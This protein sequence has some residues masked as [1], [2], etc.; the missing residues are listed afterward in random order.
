MLAARPGCRELITAMD[1]ASKR[2]MEPIQP[3]AAIGLWGE[4]FGL[5]ELPRLLL[6]FPSL[7]REPRGDGSTVLVLPGYGASDASTRVL[8]A[9]LRLLG[10]RPQGWGLGRNGGDVPRLLPR[11]LE[12]LA[13]LT[14]AA[15]RNGCGGNGGSTTPATPIALIG[16]SLGGYIARE[17]ARER[18][19]LVR[20]VITLGSPVI[21]GPKYTTVA[22]RYRR[23][24]V[25]LDRIEASIAARD[26]TPLRTPVTAVYSRNDRVVAWRACIDSVNSGVE[27]VEVTTTHVGLGFSPEVF[28]IIARS[29]ARAPEPKP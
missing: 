17:A 9:Y 12:R 16:W 5:L 19:E 4:P 27:H 15:D 29:L 21:G 3:P 10:Y 28:E 2:S 22:H 11:V 20:R 14:S 6:R 25:D 8:Q 1:R 18:P 7:A 26:A 23:Q 24:G 13:A